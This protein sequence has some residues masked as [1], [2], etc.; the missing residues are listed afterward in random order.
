MK[1]LYVRF[2]LIEEFAL[3]LRSTVALQYFMRFFDFINHAF[4]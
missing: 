4:Q 3:H 1:C 2:A